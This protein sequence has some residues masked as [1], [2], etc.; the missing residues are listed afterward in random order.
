MSGKDTQI[1]DEQALLLY[2]RKYS[3]E[4]RDRSYELK[5]LK[6]TYN[7]TYCDF[8]YKKYKCDSKASLVLNLIKHQYPNQI[9]LNLLNNLSCDILSRK[10]L[11]NVC[12]RLVNNKKIVQINGDKIKYRYINEQ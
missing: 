4:I 9:S 5:N 11:T 3:Q 2:L 1:K 8:I 10:Y 6:A 12:Q 7:K